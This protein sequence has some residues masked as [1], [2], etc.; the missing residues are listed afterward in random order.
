LLSPTVANFFETANLSGSLQ[1]KIV[2]TS[3]TAPKE[4]PI[5]RFPQPAPNPPPVTHMPTPSNEC[6]AHAVRIASEP[7]GINPKQQVY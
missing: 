7:G 2:R 3:T 1:M 4:R 5:M 6:A